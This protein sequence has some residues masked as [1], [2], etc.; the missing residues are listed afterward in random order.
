MMERASAERR[1]VERGRRREG[2]EGR[3]GRRKEGMCV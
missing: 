3:G 1:G 2:R